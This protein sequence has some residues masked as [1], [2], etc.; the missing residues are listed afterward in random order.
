MAI[1]TRVSV[2]PQTT[3]RLR[4]LDFPGLPLVRA[5]SIVSCLVV[6]QRGYEVLDPRDWLVDRM[7]HPA[8]R[9]VSTTVEV[10]VARYALHAVGRRIGQ[11]VCRRR[12]SHARSR[13]PDFYCRTKSLAVG[14]GLRSGCIHI[15]CERINRHDT[16]S[17]GSLLKENLK[18][19]W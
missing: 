13:S 5:F 9:S 2:G 3:G 14:C 1:V 18:E 10:T 11:D 17:G 4:A 8:T 15:H 7:C 16:I 19:M 6:R 12:P